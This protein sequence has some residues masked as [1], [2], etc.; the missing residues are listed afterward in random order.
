MAVQHGRKAV[1]KLNDGSSLRDVSQYLTQA[2]FNRLKELA[3]VTALGD[4]A[5]EYIA[6]LKDATISIEANY[7]PTVDG[8][9][10]S[11]YDNDST[12]AFEYYPY[13]TT[14]GN[15]F[16][17]GSFLMTSLDVDTPVSDKGT[18]SAEIQL[19]G[20]ITNGTAP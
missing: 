1:L 2:T 12:A 11:M 4:N 17:S 20:A 7:D 9:F 10:T 14:T 19:S 8:Y 16:Y 6:G 13:G 15:R 18:I 5:K 3:D